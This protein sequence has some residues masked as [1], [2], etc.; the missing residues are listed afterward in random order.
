MT[1]PR[2]GIVSSYGEECGNASYTHVLK[3]EFAKY[4][5]VEIIAINAELLSGLNR[6]SNLREV[7]ARIEA[8]DFVNIQFESG[9]YGDSPAQIAANVRAMINSAKRLVFTMHRVTPPAA[10]RSLFLLLMYNLLRRRDVANTLRT[11]RGNWLVLRLARSIAN[12]LQRKHRADPQS[13]TVMVHTQRERKILTRK[14]VATDFALNFVVDFPITFLNKGQIEENVGQRAQIRADFLHR[15]QLDDGYKYI[16]IFGFL[17]ENKGHHIA[18]EALR[19]LPREY[20]LL[21]FGGQHPASIEPYDFPHMARHPLMYM[22]NKSPYIASLVELAQRLVT[23][24]AGKAP[25]DPGQHRVQFLGVLDDQQF[26]RGITAMDF[27]VLPYLE[28]GQGG[29]A[30]ASLTLELQSR[31]VL[32]RNHA[33]T[34]LGRY[35]PG[36]FALV[37][38]ANPLQLAQTIYRWQE[39][40]TPM[41][42]DAISR[43][44]IENNVLL[45]Q[46]AFNHGARSADA[47]KKKLTEARSADTWTPD[48]TATKQVPPPS[49][50][51]RSPEVEAEL[52]ERSLTD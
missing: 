48:L 6:E 43:Y 13:V 11:W 22:R 40:L 10:P 19:F 33:F 26:I 1:L 17:S 37:D 31:C 25:N 15:H 24:D 49:G 50:V 16:G 18:I 14:L 28:S 20:R 9:L 30:N 29:S 12:E 52:V 3:M 36:C 2:L 7:C 8:C 5:D 42:R 38:M 44:N 23:N 27:V 41:Q 46:H 35:Y 4:Y 39:D 34:E 47:F 51:S 32:S 45:H 21:I